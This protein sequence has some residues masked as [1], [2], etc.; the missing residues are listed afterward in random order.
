MF[1]LTLPQ[2]QRTAEEV[3]CF[4]LLNLFLLGQGFRLTTRRVV[5][6]IRRHGNIG[7]VLYP[8]HSRTTSRKA[9]RSRGPPRHSKNRFGILLSRLTVLTSVD[10]GGYLSAEKFSAE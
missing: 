1:S 4:A 2:S 8:T 9:S 3:K 10:G 7:L 5:S 6:R